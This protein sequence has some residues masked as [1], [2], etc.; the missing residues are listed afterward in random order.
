MA[1]GGIDALDGRT[2]GHTFAL[3]SLLIWTQLRVFYVFFGFA[4]IIIIL[5]YY[6]CN[7]YL[8]PCHG[9]IKIIKNTSDQQC[10]LKTAMSKV[11]MS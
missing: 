3:C 8:L 1:V 7:M 10:S 11:K 9:E 6:C 2:D 4:N 5:F